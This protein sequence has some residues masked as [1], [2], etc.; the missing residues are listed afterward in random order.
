MIFFVL[1]NKIMFSVRSAPVIVESECASKNL[2]APYARATHKKCLSA[3][4]ISLHL[5]D[6]KWLYREK[7]KR[8]FREI[9]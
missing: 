8:L 1:L 7:G 9:N 3:R 5:S 6:E 2:T 4:F